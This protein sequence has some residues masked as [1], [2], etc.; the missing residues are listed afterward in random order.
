MAESAQCVLVTG[1]ARGIGRATAEAFAAR[2]ASVALNYL[3]NEAG[4]LQTA[5]SCRRLGAADVL[6]CQADV[7]DGAAVAAMIE[8]IAASW[9][10]LDVVVNN[11][12]YGQPGKLM[13]ITEEQ[14][15]RTF[16]THVKGAFHV[17]RNTIPLLRQSTGGVIINIGSV[18]GLR[19]LPAA[20]CYGTV[21]A[22]LHHFT[23]CLAWELADEGIRV[24]AV[25]P[26]ITRT[27][28]HLAMTAEQKALNEEKRI[29]L[30]REGQPEEIAQAI[31]ALCDN[32][33]IT[34]ETLTVDGGLT[35]R[36]C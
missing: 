31:L 20:C 22:A 33:Y 30:H 1:S 28:F 25:C 19:G 13:D 7:A 9:G 23:R 34:G 5:E 10:R 4:A 35:M 26:G 12:G 3:G 36:I 15:D 17:C 21:K 24:N 2:G 8:P 14:W 29:P 32:G 16:A 18:A 27:D 6:I 11:A